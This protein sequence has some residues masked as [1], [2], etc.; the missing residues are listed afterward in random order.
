MTNENAK[1]RHVTRHFVQSC[2][3]DSSQW[4]EPIN[5]FSLSKLYCEK[6]LN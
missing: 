2:T 3:F 4:V 5:N 6:T 1:N